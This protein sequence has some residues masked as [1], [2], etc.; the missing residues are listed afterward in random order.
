MSGTD[1][2]EKRGCCDDG[3]AKEQEGCCGK[4][5]RVWIIGA[6]FL[7]LIIGLAE[8]AMGI[9][10]KA[11]PEWSFIGNS[12]G[13]FAIILGLLIFAIS[14]LGVFAG[15]KGER[16]DCIMYVYAIVTTLLLCLQIAAVAMSMVTEDTSDLILTR[17]DETWTTYLTQADKDYIGLQF[18]CC[19]ATTEAVIGD[20]KDCTARGEE[21]RFFGTCDVYPVCTDINTDPISTDNSGCKTITYTNADVLGVQKTCAVSGA[22]DATYDDANCA[23]Y[24]DCDGEANDCIPQ[25]KS[26]GS[27]DQAFYTT[28]GG[29]Q[30]QNLVAA[31]KNEAF[32]NCYGRIE[33]WVNGNLTYTLIGFI[34]YIM[35]QILLVLFSWL[36][37]CDCCNKKPVDIE[38]SNYEKDGVAPGV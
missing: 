16:A 11:A 2:T 14:F 12:F 22:W 37:A 19:A 25:C 21:T 26:D 8:L 6:N 34:I 4:T 32:V 29:A 15:C 9:Y 38:G 7:T 17:M 13:W 33:S 3:A 27:F 35:W 24:T 28:I 1:E 36:L 10:V 31:G 20:G 23:A 5:L 30:S 18:G